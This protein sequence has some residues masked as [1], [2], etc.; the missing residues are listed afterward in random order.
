MQQQQEGSY[1]NKFNI[2]DVMEGPVFFSY[3]LQS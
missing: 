1:I 2:H 3:I